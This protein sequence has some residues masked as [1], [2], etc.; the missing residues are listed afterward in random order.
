MPPN[1]SFYTQNF[2]VLSS[3]LAKSGFFL[4][5]CLAWVVQ[6]QSLWCFELIRKN[7]I[8]NTCRYKEELKSG[9]YRAGISCIL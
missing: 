8:S 3:Q 4:Q 6:R 7:P 9:Q 1:S 2:R 5:S